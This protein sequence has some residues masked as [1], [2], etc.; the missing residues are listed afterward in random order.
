[1]L[2]IVFN[3]KRQGVPFPAFSIFTLNVKDYATLAVSA[4]VAFLAIV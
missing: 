3:R 2:W 4:A 1:M